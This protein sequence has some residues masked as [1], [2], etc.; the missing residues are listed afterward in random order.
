MSPSW[1]V[2]S[3]RLGSNL[4]CYIL[5]RRIVDDQFSFSKECATRQ[6]YRH[7]IALLTAPI[8]PSVLV[9]EL[10]SK[11]QRISSGTTFTWGHQSMH[12]IERHS[13]ANK[14]SEQ[15]TRPS[16]TSH[17]QLP[18]S[19]CV[20]SHLPPGSSP[21]SPILQIPLTTQLSPTL[22]TTN[23]NHRAQRLSPDSVIINMCLTSMLQDQIA[24]RR[25]RRFAR[26][27]ATLARN[28]RQRL[29][30]NLLRIALER[31]TSVNSLTGKQPTR[32]KAAA[33]MVAARSG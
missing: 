15:H 17:S 31:S 33:A 12:T 8:L 9:H 6:H 30:E 26:K 21:N 5:L 2:G 4:R 23:L 13:L 18:L 7:Y 22:H 1:N 16:F 32:T 11:F 24:A 27:V 14:A 29:N 25:S 19:R 20:F 3:C 10:T 28:D